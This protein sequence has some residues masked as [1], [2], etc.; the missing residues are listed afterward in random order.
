M[1]LGDLDKVVVEMVQKLQEYDPAS[2]TLIVEE[3]KELVRRSGMIVFLGRDI[4][5]SCLLDQMRRQERTIS[6]ED[7][8]QKGELRGSRYNINAQTMAIWSLAPENQ[9][10]TLMEIK[11]SLKGNVIFWNVHSTYS[12][13]IYGLQNSVVMIGKNK[14]DVLEEQLE[15]AYEQYIKTRRNYEEE[16]KKTY[17]RMEKPSV[18][19]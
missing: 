1:K 9:K 3:A 17:L 19:E 7:E 11:D 5:S 8:N 14:I 6:F 12:S 10:P 18:G 4:S 16:M 13:Y 2:E 15:G